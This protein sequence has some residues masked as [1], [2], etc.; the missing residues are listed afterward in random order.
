MFLD[1]PCIFLGQPLLDRR[2][3]LKRIDRLLV[4][5]NSP[6]CY[7]LARFIANGRFTGVHLNPVILKSCSS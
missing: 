4:L 2:V 1:M 6:A 5:S 3:R 7:N